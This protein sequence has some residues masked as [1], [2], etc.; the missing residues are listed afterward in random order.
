M[1][2]IIESKEINQNACAKVQT[3]R[4]RTKVSAVEAEKGRDTQGSTFQTFP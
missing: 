2:D 3:R 1:G 4:T